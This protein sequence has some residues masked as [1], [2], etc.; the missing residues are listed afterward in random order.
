MK[1]VKNLIENKGLINTFK[2]FKS[3]NHTF[4]S[5][6]KKKYFFF[7]KFQQ[8]IFLNKTVF[9]KKIIFRKFFILQ[10]KTLPTNTTGFFTTTDLK[11]TIFKKILMFY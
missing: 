8:K 9:N 6:S 5:V 2:K 3:K 1:R 10:L 7:T 4:K 11:N